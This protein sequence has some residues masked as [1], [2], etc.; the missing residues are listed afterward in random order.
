SMKLAIALMGVLAVAC[1][2]NKSQFE[3]NDGAVAEDAG[4]EAASN[5]DAAMQ[6]QDSTAPIDAADAAIGCNLAT[7][8]TG[9]SHASTQFEA[10]LSQDG[11][12]SLGDQT[13]TASLLAPFSVLI[14]QNLASNHTYTTTEANALYN[15]VESGGNVMTLTGYG[16]G[17]EPT[18]VNTLIAPFD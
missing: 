6:F 17:N 12:G 16:S 2:G 18:N 4:N 1:S 15:W 14:V 9:G 8:G 10:W 5:V 7:I 11:V 3:A 13:I